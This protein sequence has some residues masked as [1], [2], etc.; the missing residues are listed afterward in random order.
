MQMICSYIFWPIAVIMGVEIEDAFNVAH[1]LG[2]KVFADEFIS[3]QEL[4]QMVCKKSIQ[5]CFH[6][7]SSD[8]TCIALFASSVYLLLKL[9]ARHVNF[10]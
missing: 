9:V 7:F 8:S 2:V 1:L 10:L 3:F 6:I 4:A 5:V